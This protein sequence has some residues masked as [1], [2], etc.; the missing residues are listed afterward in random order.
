[1]RVRWVDKCDGCKFAIKWNPWNRVIQC[2]RCGYII[3]MPLNFY[4]YHKVYCTGYMFFK[5]DKSHRSERYVDN[6]IHPLSKEFEWPLGPD[7]N[8][9]ESDSVDALRRAFRR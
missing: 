4:L 8:D 5:R 7:Y 1:M 6:D 3:W 9:D 2:H